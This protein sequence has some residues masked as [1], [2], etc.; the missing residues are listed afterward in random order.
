MAAL[1]AAEMAIPAPNPGNPIANAAP[2]AMP[3]LSNC[4]VVVHVVSIL[5]C[6][7]C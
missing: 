7:D 1:P 2:I 4:P 3:T 6:I 5:N